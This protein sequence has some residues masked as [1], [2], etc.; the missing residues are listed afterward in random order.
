MAQ[1]Q[2]LS[3]HVSLCLCVVAVGAPVLSVPRLSTFTLPGALVRI[4]ACVRT[5]NSRCYTAHCIVC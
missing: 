5:A 1:L 3:C 2:D 4:R